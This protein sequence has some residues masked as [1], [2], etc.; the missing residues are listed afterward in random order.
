MRTTTTQRTIADTLE[1]LRPTPT[2]SPCYGKALRAKRLFGLAH[3]VRHAADY[4]ICTDDE[5]Q[6]LGSPEIF[7]SH[8]EAMRQSQAL[9]LAHAHR[10]ATEAMQCAIASGQTDVVLA[11]AKK[12][13]NCL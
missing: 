7:E 1:S 2:A 9:L 11:V 3:A 4:T 13:G 8:H 10:L 5:L 12:C 6:V